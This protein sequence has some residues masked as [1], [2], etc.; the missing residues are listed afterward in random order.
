MKK[1]FLTLALLLISQQTFAVWLS[2]IWESDV[3]IKEVINFKR[4]H[5]LK[6]SIEKNVE[7]FSEIKI[8]WIENFIEIFD[9][10]KWM[11]ETID[12]IK[13]NIINI[14]NPL[15]NSKLTSTLDL[16]FKLLNWKTKHAELNV[17]NLK[18]KNNDFL[19]SEIREVLE[20]FRM[21]TSRLSNKSYM[22]F[23]T[24]YT[25]WEVKISLKNFSE[26]STF[27]NGIRL[28]SN[29]NQFNMLKKLWYFKLI[30]YSERDL[31]EKQYRVN[32]INTAFKNIWN[33]RVLK[34]WEIF[35]VANSIWF[36]EY[37]PEDKR[38]YEVWA[39][40]VDWKEVH[41]Y[42]GGLCWVSTSIRNWTL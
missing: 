24:Y 41:I 31:K 20:N 27:Q 6:V 12:K 25:V 38:Q 21:K 35:S 15:I 7:N 16:N 3:N 2:Q 1:I 4:S 39:A 33:I 18:T 5:P 19:E 28:F 40:L 9:W 22:E 42:W 30:S 36:D 29:E 26:Q 13:A 23:F 11:Q 10:E 17:Q 14:N 37:L 8:S 32:N 34:P